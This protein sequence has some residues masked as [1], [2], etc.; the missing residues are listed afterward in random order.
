M[1]LCIQQ[2]RHQAVSQT[3]PV[4]Q[5]PAISVAYAL[6]VVILV[7][8]GLGLC[9]QLPLVLEAQLQQ[10]V[11]HNTDAYLHKRMCVR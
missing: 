9:V 1:Y 4:S 10:G 5:K 3:G 2:C 7:A 6:D 8:H 11:A